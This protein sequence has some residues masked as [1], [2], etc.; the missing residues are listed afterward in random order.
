M[1]RSLGECANSMEADKEE[2]AFISYAIGDNSIFQPNP[3][4]R[5]SCPETQMNTQVIEIVTVDT[6]SQSIQLLGQ[7]LVT[8]LTLF[9]SRPIIPNRSS[10][11]DGQRDDIMVSALRPWLESLVGAANSEPQLV[12]L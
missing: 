9:N 3:Q 7:R 2:M 6:H 12:L 4:V 11:E 1:E 8:R 10:R 5:Y